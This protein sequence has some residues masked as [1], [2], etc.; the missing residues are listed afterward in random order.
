MS[1]K[2]EPKTFNKLDQWIISIGQV[3]SIIFL[4]C[5]AIIIY[6][7]ISRYIFNSPTIWVSE[8]TIL[9]N[10]LLFL[11]GG[12]YVLAKNKHIRIT[13]LYDLFSN[14]VKHY[15]N[16]FIA[17]VGIFYSTLMLIASYLVAKSALFTPW[18][19]FHMETSG[20]AWDIPLPAIVKSF[21]FV[22]LFIMSIQ[23]ILYLIKYITKGNNV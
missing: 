6:E 13:I 10:A 15:I 18:G 1:K 8:T 5:A 4:F 19:T 22:I 12:I 23:Y 9:L 21:L 16:I 11:Y 7:I 20:S 14:K 17:I 2:V 3:L